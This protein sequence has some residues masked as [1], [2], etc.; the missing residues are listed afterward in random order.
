MTRQL[1]SDEA[2]P[3]TAGYA[4][5]RCIDWKMLGWTWCPCSPTSPYIH[6]SSETLGRE[7]PK[8]MQKA[9]SKLYKIWVT[10]NI[11]GSCY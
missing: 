4:S 10:K 1:R 7:K 2:T 11:L 8:W 6:K 5:W 3:S 9:G